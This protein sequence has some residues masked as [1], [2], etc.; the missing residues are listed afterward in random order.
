[1]TERIE[2]IMR[3]FVAINGTAGMF[4]G[5]A[6]G[7]A[8]YMGAGQLLRFDAFPFAFLTLL[9]SL[10]AILLAIATLSTAQGLEEW[11]KREVERVEAM[12]R[13]IL[14]AVAELV[15]VTPDARDEIADSDDEGGGDGTH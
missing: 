10:W 15:H 7:F 13:R 12:E 1:M 5:A 11:T 3:R 6:V 14:L 9:V 4:V 8:L 2:A